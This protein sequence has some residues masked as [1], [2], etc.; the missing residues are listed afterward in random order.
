MGV[1]VT[2]RGVAATGRERFPLSCRSFRYRYW[3]G[4][5]EVAVSVAERRQL[6]AWRTMSGLSQER[7]AES[8]GV[9]VSTVRNWERGSSSPHPR[10]VRRIAEVLSVSAADAAAAFGLVATPKSSRPT[11]PDAT[12]QT[13]TAAGPEVTPA[14]RPSV[15]FLPPQR[16][17]GRLLAQLCT[18]NEQPAELLDHLDSTWHSLVVTDNE[19]GPALAITGVLQALTR[20]SGTV[21]HLDGT[22][23]RRANEMQARYAESAS[24]LYEDM[25]DLA[26]ANRW[27]QAA[28]R[29][30]DQSG[31]R[32]L[33]VWTLVGRSRQAL[34]RGDATAAVLSADRALNTPI[35]IPPSIVAAALV[36]KAEGLAL[37]GDRRGA[38]DALDRADRDAARVEADR[39]PASTGGYAS[40]CDPGYVAAGRARCLHLLGRPLE[41][42]QL[43]QDSLAGLAASYYRDYGWGLARLALAQVNAGDLERATA[44]AQQAHGIAIQVGSQRTATE[45]A[46][47]LDRLHLAGYTPEWSLPVELPA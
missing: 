8:L 25:G 30:S 28:Y 46:R 26:S 19:L 31:H 4:K 27:I 1:T 37:S 13:A 44:T 3:N 47:V 9:A 18:P 24:W 40:W 2:I 11:A 45:V 36:Y 10:H 42:I 15:Q 5:Q 14:D 34:L 32:L 20:L 23:A 16:P 39:T 38:L 33:G 43:Y 21:P 41:A 29:C 17:T 35:P 12:A 6:R 22:D 7:M